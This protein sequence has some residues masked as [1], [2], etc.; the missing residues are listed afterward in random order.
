MLQAKKEFICNQQ[1]NGKELQEKRVLKNM[2]QAYNIKLVI[3]SVALIFQ[4]T[5]YNSNADHF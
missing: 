2:L 4:F 5:T 3:K 1:W